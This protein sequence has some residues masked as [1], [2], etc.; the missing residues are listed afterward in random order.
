MKYLEQDEINSLATKFITLRD[1][2]NKSKSKKVKKEYYTFQ[3]FCVEKLKFLVTIKTGRYRQFSNHPDLEQDGLEALVLALKTYNPS[4]GCFSWWADKYIST[5][6]SRAAN[7]HST[8]RFPLKKAKLV[9]P[10]KTSTMPI[11]VDTQ[12]D[13]QQTLETSQQSQQ[14]RQAIQKLPIQHQ[15]IV[16]MVYGLNGIKQHSI[17][18]LIKHLAISRPQCL[19]ILEEAKIQLKSILDESI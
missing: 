10:Y 13:A 3:N 11:M 17:G 9:R 4:K 19:K 16:N 2:A 6:I 14:V 15:E 5:R 12:P 7:T 18:A 1:K 8:I